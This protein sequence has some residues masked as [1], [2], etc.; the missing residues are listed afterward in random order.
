MS[1][2]LDVLVKSV[3]DI[4]DNTQFTTLK[5]PKQIIKETNRIVDEIAQNVA[6]GT[7]LSGRPTGWKLIDKYLG[8]YN[9]GDLIVVAGRPGMGKTAIALSLIKDFAAIGGKGLFLGLEMS[10]DQLARRYISLI[11]NIPNYKI[12]KRQP[13]GV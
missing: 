6:N 11:G 10:N 8:G 7:K 3:Q 5:D 4:V 12:R 13:I 1:T 2:E 9:G